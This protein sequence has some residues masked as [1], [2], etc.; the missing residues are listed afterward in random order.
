[1]LYIKTKPNKTTIN[2]NKSVEGESIELKIRRITLNREPITD[3]A[4]LVY[5]ERKNGVDPATD[6]RTDKWAIA[7]D[8]M[9][10]VHQTKQGLIKE[11]MKTPEIK[12][13]ERIAKEAAKNMKSEGENSPK[14]N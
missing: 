12:E 8:A 6:V 9:E 5:T 4:E 10:T 1:M 11:K 2:V 3:G 7:V 13:Q 14:N